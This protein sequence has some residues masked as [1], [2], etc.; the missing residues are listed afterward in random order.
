MYATPPKFIGFRRRSEWLTAFQVATCLPAF[1]APG[2]IPVAL[3]SSLSHWLNGSGLLAAEAGYSAAERYCLRIAFL[4]K[5]YQAFET[6]GFG[7]QVA[8]AIARNALDVLEETPVFGR[9]IDSESLFLAP[10][11]EAVL[12]HV[13]AVHEYYLAHA[14]IRELEFGCPPL[15]VISL[16]F[17]S[18]GFLCTVVLPAE[19]SVERAR[20]LWRQF[21]RENTAVRLI[22]LGSD[23]AA[24]EVAKIADPIFYAPG[25]GQKPGRCLW[26]QLPGL[27]PD[28]HQWLRQ[29]GYANPEYARCIILK[30]SGTLSTV[31]TNTDAIDEF[32]LSEAF[33]N[34]C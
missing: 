28:I 5:I 21:M 24:C 11:P 26:S 14:P 6:A 4:W 25:G 7:E 13:K 19:M 30:A 18:P 15:A 10:F 31:L 33:F 27:A 17:S 20:R 34:A 1:L 2:D 22:L 9:P 8:E 29:Q 3:A 16:P 12:A 32:V 23:P